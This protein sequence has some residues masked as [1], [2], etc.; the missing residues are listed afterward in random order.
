MNILPNGQL[1]LINLCLH[2]GCPDKARNKVAPGYCWKHRSRVERHGCSFTRKSNNSGLLIKGPFCPLFIMKRRSG[3][4]WGTR[5]NGTT[6]YV[7]RILAEIK[8]GRPLKPNEQTHHKDR[9]GLHNSMDNIEVLTHQD[10]VK[11]TH[12]KPDGGDP[13]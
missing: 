1:P 8:L 6:K 3:L 2:P 5:I 12:Q 10:H 13:F 7:H 11:I 4:Y 9:N